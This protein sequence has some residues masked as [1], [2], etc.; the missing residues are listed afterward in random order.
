MKTFAFIFARKNSSR[1]KNKNLLKLKNISLIDCSIKFALNCKIFDKVIVSTDIDI[2]KFYN[3]DQRIFVIKRPKYLSGKNSNELLAWRHAIKTCRSINLDFE[4]FISLP[5]TSPFRKKTELYYA[6]NY[7]LKNNIDIMV[8]VIKS[9][10]VLNKNV[11]ILNN[12]KLKKLKSIKKEYDYYEMTTNYY[13]SNPNYIMK[14]KNILE[15]KI[16]P[17]FI[18]RERSIDIDY[19]EDYLVAKS[20]ANNLDKIFT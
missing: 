12:N 9:N 5:P 10:K 7:Y 3:N 15:G 6:I 1:L 19:L 11:L 14:T 8:S 18:P 4:I 13:I 16:A 2:K 17:I 20:M